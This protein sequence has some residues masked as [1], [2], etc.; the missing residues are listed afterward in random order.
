MDHDDDNDDDNGYLRELV[1][2]PDLSL[3]YGHTKDDRAMPDQA[4]LDLSLQLQAS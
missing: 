4:M 3:S 1:N 2:H